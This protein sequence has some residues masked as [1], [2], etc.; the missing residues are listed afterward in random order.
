MPKLGSLPFW[1][2]M[3]AMLGVI[4]IAIE[5]PQKILAYFPSSTQPQQMRQAPPTS[6]TLI[7][8]NGSVSVQ[9]NQDIKVEAHGNATV[10]NSVSN[11]T[12]IAG[13]FSGRK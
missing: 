13:S 2:L 11:N 9:T 6:Y 1:T 10:N 12:S 5:L 7:A 3:A 8:P 4:S